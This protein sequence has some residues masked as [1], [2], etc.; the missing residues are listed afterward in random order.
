MS[1]LGIILTALNANSV[2]GSVIAGIC[3]TAVNVIEVDGAGMTVISQTQSGVVCTHGPFAELGEDLQFTLGEGPCREAM[4]SEVLIEALSLSSNPRWPFF[5]AQMAGAGVKSVASFPVR[6][7]GA[8]IGALTV[9]RSESDALSLEQ[10]S[11]G[12][13]LAQISAHVISAA[14]AKMGKGRF[15]AEM[16][17]GFGRMEPVHQ[18]TGLLMGKLGLN[19]GDALARLRSAAYA[20][21]RSIIDLALDLVS[22]LVELPEGH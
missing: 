18:A 14:Q 19:A 22:G 10:A 8:R 2:E 7:G 11:N 4:T 12:Y 13:V 21:D 15:I 6:I 20:A 3:K 1:R 9:Y 17:A 5:S 16:E